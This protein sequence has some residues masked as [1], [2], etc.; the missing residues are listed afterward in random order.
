MAVPDEAAF[1]IVH[2]EAPRLLTDSPYATR[3]AECERAAHILG[4]PLGLCALGDL[5][6]LTD[7]VLR[8]RARHVITECARVG[9]AERLLARGN[10]GGLGAVMTEGHRSLAADYRVSVPAVDDL[11]EHLL[12]QPGVLGARMSGGGFGGCV[13][14]L[15]RPDSPALEPDSHAPA[16]ELAGQPGC[17]RS[18]SRDV[19][20][21]GVEH[22]DGP[23]ARRSTRWPAPAR[24]PGPRPV[25]PPRA[26]R[27]R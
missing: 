25:P 3:R 8:R 19:A 5:S 21:S 27:P 7:P 20:I 17:R 12:A 18:S 26:R 11:V 14:A 4:R 1:V 9:E 15:C 13:I 6:A 10:L 2:S 16:P 22:A 23:A 24:S